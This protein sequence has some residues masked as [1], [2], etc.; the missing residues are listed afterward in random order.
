MGRVELV[1]DIGEVGQGRRSYSLVET[2]LEI[3]W[4]E[5]LNIGIVEESR[6]RG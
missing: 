5:R 2:C 3:A 4:W 6:L 1:V